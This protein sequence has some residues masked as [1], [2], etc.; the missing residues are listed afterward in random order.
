MNETKLVPRWAAASALVVGL[1]RRR[2][3]D[4]QCGV[5]QE[6]HHDD[7]DDACPPAR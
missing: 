2:L 4:R 1:D 6:R 5:W 7:N 3:R